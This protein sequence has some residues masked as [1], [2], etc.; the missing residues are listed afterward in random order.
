MNAEVK[1]VPLMVQKQWQCWDRMDWQTMSKMPRPWLVFHLALPCLVREWTHAY[2]NQ[3]T[4]WPH[5]MTSI[6]SLGMNISKPK[7]SEVHLCFH[8]PSIKFSFH[9]EISALEGWCYSQYILEHFSIVLE[10]LERPQWHL[11]DL[12]LE[13]CKSQIEY[14]NF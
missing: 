7:M 11:S 4:V 12:K 5:L 14:T 6:T 2:A 3:T 9:T 1:P 13:M 10:L 8:F